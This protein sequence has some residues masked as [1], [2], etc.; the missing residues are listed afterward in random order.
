M[1][2]KKGGR[3]S[4]KQK[5][6]I[7]G[8]AEG[9]PVSE[10]A[11]RAGFS[12]HQATHGV[13]KMINRPTFQNRIAE[14]MRE[15]GLD[16]PVLLE[17]LRDGLNATRTNAKGEEVPDHQTRHRFLETALKVRGGFAPTKSLKGSISFDLADVL[18]Q[19]EGE[20]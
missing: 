20:E 14:L 5:Q 4:N 10:A 1:V 8:V 3:L 9:L 17:A 2:P 15:Q 18:R 7:K 6:L 11:R 16:D 12:E 13:Y 19:A